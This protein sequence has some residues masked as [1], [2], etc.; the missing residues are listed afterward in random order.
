MLLPSL[1]KVVTYSL[2]MLNFI[3]AVYF[4]MWTNCALL[5][6]LFLMKKG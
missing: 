2:N 3:P 5:W 1:N 4:N 6:F